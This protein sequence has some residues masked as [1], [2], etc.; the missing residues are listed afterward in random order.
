[1][2]RQII[3][4]NIR[5]TVLCAALASLGIA[6][7]GLMSGAGSAAAEGCTSGCATPASLVSSSPLIVEKP[8]PTKVPA[9]TPTV[10]ESLSFSFTKVDFQY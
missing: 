8:K 7:L 1:M 4:R 3:R 5:R 2:G 10:T 6:A 9:K